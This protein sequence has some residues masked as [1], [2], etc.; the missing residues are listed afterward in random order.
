MKR[1]YT[2]GSRLGLSAWSALTGDVPVRLV[3]VKC[4]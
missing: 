3:G 1:L 2:D 4:W